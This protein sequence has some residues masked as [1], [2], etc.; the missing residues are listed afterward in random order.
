[1]SGHIIYRN[2]TISVMLG[3]MSFGLLDLSFKGV[4][5][6]TNHHVVIGLKLIVIDLKLVR[7]LIF[8][9]DRKA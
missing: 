5:D 1:M 8:I 2:Y 4:T 9:Q 7:R 3:H 6:L